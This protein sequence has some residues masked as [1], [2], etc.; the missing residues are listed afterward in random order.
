[1]GVGRVFVSLVGGIVYGVLD[2]IFPA[3]MYKSIL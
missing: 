3:Y 1:M 2:V